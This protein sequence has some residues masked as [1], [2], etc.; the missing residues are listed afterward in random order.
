MHYLV[1]VNRL[2]LLII[3]QSGLQTDEYI[4]LKYENLN[5]LHKTIRVDG[6]WDSYH[7]M[8]KEAKTQNAKQTLSITEKARD[9]VQI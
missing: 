5:F 1:G 9:W 7:S 6:A 8:T 4:V 2:A 3:S